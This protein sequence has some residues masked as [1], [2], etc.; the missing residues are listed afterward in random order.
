MST[1][2]WRALANS[3]PVVA[4]CLLLVMVAG[5]AAVGLLAPEPLRARDILG[6]ESTRFPRGR[7]V[8]L[9]D[10]ASARTIGDAAAAARRSRSGLPLEIRLLDSGN[11]VRHQ[12]LRRLVGAYGF[13]DLPLLLTLD[14]EARVLRVEPLEP[15]QST[16]R[17]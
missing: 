11:D 3:L 10:S 12:R 2:R 13:Q 9:A 16:P 15:G 6:A 17:S 1:A 14:A 5:R 7:L 8:V 4:T